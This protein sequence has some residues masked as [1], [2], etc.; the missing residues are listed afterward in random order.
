MSSS[1]HL[2][3]GLSYKFLHPWLGKGLLTSHGQKWFDRRKLITPTFHFKMLDTFLDVHH[4]NS[5]IL[6]DKLGRK[7]E[8]GEVFDVYPF[9]TSCALDIICGLYISRF[10]K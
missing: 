2:T 10:V 7:A 5:E 6:A 4:E 3:K 1:R 9:I 8:T